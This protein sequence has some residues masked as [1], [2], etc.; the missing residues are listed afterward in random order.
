MTYSESSPHLEVL[1][2]DDHDQSMEFILLGG[3]YWRLDFSKINSAT[4]G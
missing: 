3:V 4:G 2:E 1:R